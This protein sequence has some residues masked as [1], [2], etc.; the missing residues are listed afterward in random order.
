[1][2]ALGTAVILLGPLGAALALQAPAQDGV[3]FFERRV[4]PILEERCLKCHASTLAKPKGGLALDSRVAWQRGGESGEVIVAGDADA[5][6]LIQAVRYEDALLQM[7]PKGRLTDAE[8]A[9]LEAWVRMGAPDPRDVA[10]EAAHKPL[11]V[12]PEAAARH[13]AFQPLADAP[14]PPVADESWITNDIDR[15]VLARLEAEGPRARARA[16]RRT[17]LRRA[18]DDL[19]GLPPTPR[20]SRASPPTREPDAWSAQVERLLA[21]PHYGERWGALARPRALRRLQRARREPRARRR[22]ALPRLGRA[23]AQR[24]P[25]LRPLR[26][27]SS[28]PATSCRRRRRRELRRRLIATGFLVLGPK[29]L[30]EQ[31]KG[32]S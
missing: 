29:M 7:P 28:S 1:V 5:S 24:G 18:S 31:D 11:A 32:S 22:V 16:D 25:A 13:W 6:R 23:R 14:P 2:R 30:A 9:D 26:R 27:R 4:R 20:S 12:D 3:D 21:S 10:A 19:T 15:F 17:L 8:V